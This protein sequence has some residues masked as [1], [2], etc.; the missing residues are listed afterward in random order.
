MAHL[1]KDASIFLLAVLISSLHIEARIGIFLDYPP[2]PEPQG[3]ILAPL[4]SPAFEPVPGDGGISFPP[5]FAPAPAE[6]GMSFP[7][8]LAP[9]PLE[10]DDH[11]YHDSSEFSLKETS[12]ATS[13]T[14]RAATTNGDDEDEFLDEDIANEELAEN[15]N[16]GNQ[17]T[18]NNNYYNNNRYSNANYYNNGYA[19]NYQRNEMSDTRFLDNGKNYY[20][21]NSENPQ[22]DDEINGYESVKEHS[23]ADEDSSF[24]YGK[25]PTYEFDTMEEY[26]RL[27]GY[28]DP[29][30]FYNP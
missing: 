28:P 25:K 14:T 4:A 29:S 10:S 9:A 27:Q 21:V 11:P 5:E 2:E 20:N 13:T 3:P 24:G 30:K 17:Y 12:K 16:A 15:Y 6:N 8:E 23:Y 26:E 1:P 19:S 22:Q 7:P 18:N